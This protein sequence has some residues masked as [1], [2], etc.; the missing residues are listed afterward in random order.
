[1]GPLDYFSEF[2]SKKPLEN[3]ILNGK[4]TQ[5]YGLRGSS[6]AFLCASLFKNHPK[7]IL[8]ICADKERSAYLYNE[9]QSIINLNQ[10]HYF[11]DLARKPYDSEE[12]NN[13]S[14]QERAELLNRLSNA[15]STMVIVSTAISISEKVIGK[16][17]LN[18]NTLQIKA[19]EKI[20]LE[21]ITEFLILNDFTRVDFVS[22]PG[23]FAVRGG[24]VDVFSFSSE[25]PFRFELF[26][27][28]VESI[29]SFDPIT[30]LSLKLF[31]FITLIPDISRQ[32]FAETTQSILNYLPANS[33]I[34]VDN[35]EKLVYQ[36]DVHFSKAEKIYNSLPE[37]TQKTPDKLYSNAVEIK[38]NL[39][40]FPI[41][42][43]EPLQKTQENA[44]EFLQD[45]QPS[46]NKNFD[47]F[48][49]HLHENYKK[50]YKN[51][52]LTE[53]AKQAERLESI[54]HDLGLL[55]NTGVEP[56]RIFEPAWLNVH[57][58][59]IDH[60]LKIAAYTDHQLFER[61]HKFFLKGG[62]SKKTESLTLK[63]I[64]NLN[65]GD[66]VT[67]IDH[68]VGRFAGLEKLIVNGKEQEAVKLVYKD[69]DILLVSVHSLHR[70]SK[71]SGKEGNV[72]RIDKLGST[73]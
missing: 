63:E 14:V 48:F 52:F 1:M 34:L 26:G 37:T 7:T 21:F 8:L 39:Q 18:S 3:A 66:F 27:D 56:F 67:H 30:Q 20:N 29:R 40:R 22:E 59:F 32:E 41:V 36:S 23:Q 50:G 33:I 24:I 54:F 62:T 70:I 53:S 10:V 64:Q 65:P 44:I 35:F 6:I 2:L 47:L 4:F 31:H 69:N 46:F 57:E 11:P 12:T 61:Y 13:A 25:N 60:E 58:G 17:T 73:H 38:N 19:G 15:D 49:Q 16:A 51:Y 72:P 45:P 71:Y 5:L 43:F 28:E 9:L 42:E 55:K 68:G